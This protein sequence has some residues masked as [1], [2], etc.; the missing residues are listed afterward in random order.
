LKWRIVKPVAGDYSAR[1]PPLGPAPRRRHAQHP[2]AEAIAPKIDRQ[3]QTCLD[4]NCGGAN[5]AGRANETARRE[6]DRQG[7][8]QS[9]DPGSTKAL[10]YI[11]RPSSTPPG[12]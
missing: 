11:T 3:L 4:G 2:L 5:L 1:M 10:A 6:V 8:R 9:G 12:R 7:G